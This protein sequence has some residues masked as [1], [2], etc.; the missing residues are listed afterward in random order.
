MSARTA[1]DDTIKNAVISAL[2]LVQ[3]DPEKPYTTE[4]DCSD[5][6]DMIALC[7]EGTNGKTSSYCV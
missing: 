7:Q 1:H 6:G 5:L 4:M 2:V 3:P